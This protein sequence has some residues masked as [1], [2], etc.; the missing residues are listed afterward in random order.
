MMQ[1]KTGAVAMLASTLAFGSLQAQTITQVSPVTPVTAASLKVS[2]N[3]TPA[4]LASLRTELKASKK[5][6]TAETLK[7]TADEATRFWPIYDEYTEQMRS[8]IADLVNTGGRPAGACTAAVFLKEFAGSLPWAHLDIAGTAW[9]DD[10]KP[11]QPKG[12]TG[13]AVRTLAELALSSGEWA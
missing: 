7:I 10:A 3:L 12:P 9:A 2:R 4:D 8:E 13:V 5:Q 11:W 1:V 6:M